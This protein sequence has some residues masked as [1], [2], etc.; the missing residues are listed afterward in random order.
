MIK[1]K[2]SRERL[3]M[4]ILKGLIFVCF[5]AVFATLISIIP[6]IQNLGISSLV[7]AIILGMVYANTYG[8]KLSKEYDAGI[9]FA[10]KKVLRF[11]IV[12]YGFRITFGQIA[13]VGMEGFLVSL[14]ML[15]STFIIGSYVGIKWFKL[16]KDTA[17][18]NASGA[19]VCGAAAVLA[20]EGSLKSD[21]HKAAIAVSMVV[22]FGTVALFLYPFLYK[23]GVFQMNAKE[24]GIYIGGTVHEVAQ[25]VAIGGAFGEDVANNAVIV[26]MT[27]VMLIAPMLIILG[28]YLSKFSTNS[29]KTKLVIPWFAVYFIGVAGFNSLN[30]LPSQLVHTINLIDTFLLT[31]AMAALGI[32]TN[33]SK[34]KGYAKEAFLAALVMFAWL[35][36]GGYFIVKLI[37]S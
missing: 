28:I 13:D 10:A 2:L 8:P 24:F 32:G 12:F 14:I 17:F 6:T 34:F 18:L 23:I 30:L 35:V 15:S 3:K 16:D 37:V 9:T 33:F 22:L 11:A 5:F 20:T 7:I 26:K 27:R 36:V 21:S 19:S 25:V 1:S 31:I 29:T 4:K